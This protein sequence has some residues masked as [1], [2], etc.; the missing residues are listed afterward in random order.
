MSFISFSH[1]TTL[2]YVPLDLSACSL[3]DSSTS[4]LVGSVIFS[5]NHLV[6]EEH[7]LT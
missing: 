3:I 5:E 4:R 1:H 2:N 7:S 6:L